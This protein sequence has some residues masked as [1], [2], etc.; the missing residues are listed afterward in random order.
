MMVS[1]LIPSA[2]STAYIGINVV[3]PKMAEKTPFFAT[4]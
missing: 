1:S 4:W 2:V 3:T